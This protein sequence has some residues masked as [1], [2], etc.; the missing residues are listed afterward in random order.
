MLALFRLLLFVLRLPLRLL[1]VLRAV[2]AFVT[3]GVPLL[4]AAAVVG[5]VA[6]FVFVR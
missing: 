4:I 1:A 6:W 3:C 2:A 5:G